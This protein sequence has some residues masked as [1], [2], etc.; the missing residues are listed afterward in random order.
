MINYLKQMNKKFLYRATWAPTRK[1]QIGSFGT[2]N[3]HRWTEE[4]S[5]INDYKLNLRISKDY[6]E[7]SLEF[8]SGNGTSILF[9]AA[10]E[11][12]KGFEALTDAEA[13]A[14][15]NFTKENSIVF[16]ANGI[17]HHQLTNKAVLAKKIYE[18][19][20]SG[21]WETEYLI[22]SEVLETKTVTILVSGE[23]NSKI[24]LFAEAT[25]GS[26]EF[27]IADASLGLEV[28]KGKNIAVKVL[29]ESSLTPLYQVVKL[30]KGFFSG[31]SLNIRSLEEK[32]V[33]DFFEAVQFD[34]SALD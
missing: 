21:L 16:K 27:D 25:L 22:V 2:F 7:S 3:N 5:L 32:E 30:K 15:V 14:V 9:K 31:P 11:T 17:T 1:M 26:I 12:A 13:G 23:A 18:L 34:P 28:V 19:S 4:G 10:G 20:Q 33:D 24:E 29:A 8:T 6:S